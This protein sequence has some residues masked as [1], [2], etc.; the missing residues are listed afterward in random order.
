MLKQDEH[1]LHPE[2]S[3]RKRD[4][5]SL[6]LTAI[7]NERE[8]KEANDGG[9]QKDEVSEKDI[10]EEKEEYNNMDSASVNRTEKEVEEA[11]RSLLNTNVRGKKGKLKKINTKYADQDEEEKLMRMQAL[12]TLKQIQEREK[13][14]EEEAKRNAEAEKEKYVNKGAERSN[15]KEIRQLKKYLQDDEDSVDSK[16]LEQLDSLLPRAAK[17]D[18]IGSFVPVFAP[19][20]ALNKFK[21]KVK[22]QPGLGKKGKSVT[23]AI[24]Y[25]SSRKVEKTEDVEVDW[26]VEHELL[27]GARSNDI[28]GVFTVSKVK[29]VL[30]G[31]NANDKGK[32]SGKGG[33]KKAGKKK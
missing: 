5:E 19:W 8:Q 12:G 25:F 24:L 6:S 18:E 7:L 20:S 27:K 4:L 31:S 32:G 33:G 28:I 2:V 15:L 1:G 21:Y 3:N 10:S 13:Q 17:G 23:E 22:I 16:Y 11:R 9:F 29:L 26:P 30:P 14:K